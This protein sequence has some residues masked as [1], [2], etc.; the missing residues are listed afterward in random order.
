MSDKMDKHMFKELKEMVQNKAPSDPV[1]KVLSI[2]CERHGLSINSC[3][4][5]YNL[6]L[7]SGE[8]KE[9]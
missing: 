1:E 9:K 6:L 5:Y 2:F 4:H 7:E 8:I 3:R